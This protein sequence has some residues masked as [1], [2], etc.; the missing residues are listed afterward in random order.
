M[1]N[2]S[3][4]GPSRT[5]SARSCLPSASHQ[6]ALS[7]PGVAWLVSLWQV[8]PKTSTRKPSN[9]KIANDE[10]SVATVRRRD[11]EAALGADGVGTALS[12]RRR[13]T[14]TP[15]IAMHTAARA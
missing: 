6:A 7:D 5:G 12:A 1:R 4:G 9:R 13:Q 14:T 8:K 2:T 11:V 15:A 10:T 3:A